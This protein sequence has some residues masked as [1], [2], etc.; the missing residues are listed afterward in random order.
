MEMQ[1]TSIGLILVIAVVSIVMVAL[2]SGL[3]GA[4]RTVPNTGNVKT[5]G[6]EAYWD[7][8]CTSRVSSIDWGLMEAGGSKAI[9]IYVRNNG[10]AAETLSMTT[11]NWNPSNSSSQ[12]SL[13]WNCTNYAL[14]HESVVGALLTLSV[15]STVSG[16]SNFSFNIV[17]TGAES[18]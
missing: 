6:V 7:S 12:I 13:V 14:A 2:V 4:G 8:A 16:I 3:L 5:I 9:G 18:T 17:I 10:T 11:S 15:S 1:K